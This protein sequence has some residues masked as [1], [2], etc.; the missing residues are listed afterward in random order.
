M[1]TPTLTSAPVHPVPEPTIHRSGVDDRIVQGEWDQTIAR[2]K[3]FADV[4][5]H[6]LEVSRKNYAHLTVARTPT[7]NIEGI[8]RVLFQN[9]LLAPRVRTMRETTIEFGCDW[10]WRW[11][12]AVP[13]RAEKVGSMS[14]LAPWVPREQ[15]T[16]RFNEIEAE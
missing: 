2:L 1:S 16:Y 10:L 12:K 6:A 15:W 14:S 4:T 7:T 9:L 8:E 5:S 3:E 11:R 13:F